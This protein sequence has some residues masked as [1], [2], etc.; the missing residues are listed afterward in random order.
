MNYS[1]RQLNTS[2]KRLTGS[3]L[4]TEELVDRQLELS[5]DS[6]RLEDIVC[7]V[8]FVHPSSIHPSIKTVII[9]VIIIHI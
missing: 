1:N 4:E 8:S 2:S 3:R 7:E 5:V 6:G 9:I